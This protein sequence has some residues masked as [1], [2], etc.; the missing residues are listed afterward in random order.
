MERSDFISLVR[1]PAQIAFEKYNIYASITIAQAI[2]E[3][4]FGNFIPK[5][6]ATGRTSYNLFG[7]KGVGPSGSVHVETKE[8]LQGSWVTKT[9]EFK[10]YHSFLESIEDHSQLLLRPRYQSVIQ[11]TTPYQAAQQLEQAGYATDP[12]YAEKLQ[13]IIKTYNLIQYD[14]KKSPSENFVATWKLEIGER[15]LAEGIITSPEW[16]HDLD[17]PMPVWAV[18]AV[19]LRVYDKCREGKETR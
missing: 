11:A 13:N 7:I 12:N 1:T 16:L 4:G 18:L 2:L 9:Q 19:A 8:Y 17:K 3:S 14:Q 15:A 5:D 10:A 6:T